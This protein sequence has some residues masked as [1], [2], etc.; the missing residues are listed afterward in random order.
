MFNPRRRRRSSRRNPARRSRRSSRRG[1]SLRNP[2]GEIVS[3]LF[4]RDALITTA[5]AL[6]YTTVTQIVMNKLL[7][8]QMARSGSLPGLRPGAVSPIGMTIYKILLGGLGVMLLRR[9]APS[10]AQGVALGTTI[11][12]G[13]DLLKQS[14]VL[15]QLGVPGA[16]RYLAPGRG[17]GAYTPGVNPIFTGPGASFLGGGAPRARGAGT[18][19]SPTQTNAMI[20]NTPDFAAAN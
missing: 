12:V 15:A 18:M 10:F 17:A 8:S 5:G 16:G 6:T 4:N 11:L 19:L 2:A 20:R 13:S 14:N 1:F 9:R 3:D 7:Q